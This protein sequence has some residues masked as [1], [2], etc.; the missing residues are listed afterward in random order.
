VKCAVLLTQLP[1]ELRIFG[2]HDGWR[3][4]RH[5]C[6]HKSVRTAKSLQVTES[7]TSEVFLRHRQ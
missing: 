7:I 2:V 1:A 3:S 6:S 4:L 5:L